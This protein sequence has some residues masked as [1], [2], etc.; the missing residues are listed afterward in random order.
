MNYALRFGFPAW[1]VRGSLRAFTAMHDRAPYA[2]IL[3]SLLQGRTFELAPHGW[4]VKFNWPPPAGCGL[5][6]YSDLDTL[7]IQPP[8]TLSKR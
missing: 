5:A 6:N 1:E 4:T 2:A 8:L 3:V 7:C